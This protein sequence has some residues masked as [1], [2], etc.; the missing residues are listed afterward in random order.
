MISLYG[1]VPP[2]RRFSPLIWLYS[3]FL[4][5]GVDHGHPGF[6]RAFSTSSPAPVSLTRFAP[7]WC[8]C[9]SVWPLRV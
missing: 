3:N 4:P 2:P 6:S 5:F 1:G 7:C 8:R 9:W